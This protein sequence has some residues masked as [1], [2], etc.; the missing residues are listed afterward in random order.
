MAA[1]NA[2]RSAIAETAEARQPRRVLDLGAHRGTLL[3]GV[4]ARCDP[5]HA[6][7]L[8][9]D[10]GCTTVLSCAFEDRPVTVLE[11]DMIEAEELCDRLGEFGADLTLACGLIHHLALARS[12]GIER[13]VHLIST[14]TGE[15]PGATLILEW[16]PGDDEQ[17]RSLYDNPL[18]RSPQ[19]E[20]YSF[21]ALL[22]A[23]GVGWSVETIELP[24]S[25]RCL[26]RCERRG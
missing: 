19:I 24:D 5:E 9:C 4:L 18:H 11:A 20:R 13:A 21:D 6:I 1:L 10:P 26:L 12:D 2:R 22:A 15:R 23:L 25:R 14:C 8:D 3:A 16:I 17:L 7:A